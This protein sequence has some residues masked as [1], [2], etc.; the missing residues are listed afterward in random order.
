MSTLRVWRTSALFLLGAVA[1]IWLL[2]V[3]LALVARAAGC[4]R[5]TRSGNDCSNA[6]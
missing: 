6:P 2:Q 1:L 4:G 5:A 3:P